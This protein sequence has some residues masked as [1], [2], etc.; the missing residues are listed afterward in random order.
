MDHTIPFMMA[1]D[2]SLDIGVDTRSPVDDYSLPFAFTGT[3]NSVTYTLRPEQ[4]SAA[5][6]DKMQKVIAAARDTPAR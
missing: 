1:L 5:D 4:L 3:I 6:R 2:E